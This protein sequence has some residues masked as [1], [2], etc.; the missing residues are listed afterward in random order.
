MACHYPN[1]LAYY[2][3]KYCCVCALPSNSPSLFGLKSDF[4]PSDMLCAS[5]VIVDTCKEA[6][7]N[8]LLGQDANCDRTASDQVERHTILADIPPESRG[9][10]APYETRDC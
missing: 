9:M 5:V 6:K 8:A 7:L 2:S 4:V 1:S 10:R 3:R